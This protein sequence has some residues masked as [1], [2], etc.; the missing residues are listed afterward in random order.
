LLV[1]LTVAV[2]TG[3]TDSWDISARE[4]FRPDFVWGD[5]Q[6][7]ANHVVFWLG[8]EKILTVFVIGCAVV[9]L[10]R[11]T[12]WPLV[13]GGVV[14][15]ATAGMVLALKFLVDRGD[16]TGQHTSLGGSFP[17]GHSA[18]LLVCVATGAMLISCPTRWWQ[19]GG[20]LILEGILAVSML[21]VGLH[22]LTDIVGGA[23]VAGVVL[24]A[25][26]VVVGPRGGWSHRG[27]HHRLRRQVRPHE[28]AAV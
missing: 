13:Q 23:L 1:G 7:R 5:S 4:H 15:A 20:C 25:E 21:S 27:R 10:W 28:Q 3:G 16:P 11:L 17:S 22:W 18:V 9:S 24:G 14:V 2:A 6:Q 19:W 12:L 8:P 26:A